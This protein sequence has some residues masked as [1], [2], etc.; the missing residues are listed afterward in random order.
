MV[1]VIIFK[2][3]I[4]DNNE[5]GEDDRGGCEQGCTNTI[6]SFSCFCGNGFTLALDGKTCSGSQN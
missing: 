6:G 2:L 5:C 4:S 3:C 1:C